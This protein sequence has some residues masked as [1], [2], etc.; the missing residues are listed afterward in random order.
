MD[1][2]TST[3]DTREF[4]EVQCSV[5]RVCPDTAPGAP[6]FSRLRHSLSE[7]ARRGSSRAISRL[8]AGAPRR[9]GSLAGAACIRRP[10]TFLTWFVLAAVLLP[11]ASALGLPVP[12]GWT[13]LFKGVD[14]S[15]GTNNSGIA[16]NFTNPGSSPYMQVVRCIRVDLSDPDIRLFSTPRASGY[17]A[18]SRETLTETVP[19][20]LKQYSLQVVC[21]ANYYNANPGG[22]DPTAEGI[23]CEVFGLQISTGT[24][25]SAQSAADSTIDARTCTLLFSTNN[26]P[27]IVFVNRPPGTNTAG[28]YTAIT[29]Y[30]PLVSNGVNIAAAAASSYPDS[31]IHQV[32]P[33][34]AYGVS[35]DNRY[36]YLMTIDGRQSG[37]SDGSL[38]TETAY[39]LLQFGAWNGINMDGGG[40]TAMYMADA[41][42][43]PIGVN[44]SSYLP[45][46]GHERYIGSHFGV[47]AKPVPGFINDVGALPDDTAATIT[48]TTTAP[49]NSQVQYGPTSNLGLTSSLSAAMVTNHAVLLSGLTPGTGYYYRVLSSDGANQHT[50]SNFFFT[51][52]VYAT[53]N[54]LVD[55]ANSWTYDTDNLDGVN[56]TASGFDDSAWTGSGPGLL[57]VDTSGV[58]NPNIPL[59]TLTQMPV[60]PATGY[61]YPTYYLRMHFTYTNGLNGVS[62]EF[63]DYLDDGAVFYLNGKEIQRVRMPAAP[64]P[65]LNATLASGY[66]CSNSVPPGN[67][68]CP[69]IW[70][71]AGDLATNLVTGDNVLA[72]EVHN[73]NTAS[74]DITFGTQVNALVSQAVPAQL[75]IQQTGTNVIV[76]WTRGGFTLQQ[77]NS[78]AGPWQNIPGPVVSSPYVAPSSGTSQYFRLMK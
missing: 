68:V 44:H 12:G 66:P 54:L 27:M 23:Q 67:A 46:T 6:A 33:R 14:Q 18:E 71:V 7:G 56:W 16:G 62:L 65:I 41:A 2:I 58:P 26:Q 15:S 45:A 75:N 34:T 72:V 10:V 19:D 8:K 61:P 70:S 73:Y 50:S 4:R 49:A 28:I 36:L 69:D 47:F 76:S 78:P 55:F 53:T 38:D 13:P 20:V 51:T 57:W 29:G 35:R 52:L 77:A 64:N 25:V 17:V 32:Q 63:T 42:G 30:Y 22:A 3:A 37:Y 60:N 1:M 43:N 31:F 9:E 48:W 21:D 24:V 59:P 40:S 39:W 11:I 5:Q 74:P